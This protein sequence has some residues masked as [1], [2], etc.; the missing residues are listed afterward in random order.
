[1]PDIDPNEL[2]AAIN[3]L[4]APKTS[5]DRDAELRAAG[6]FVADYGA[7]GDWYEGAD[8]A[9]L[10]FWTGHHDAAWYMIGHWS[11][12]RNDPEARPP[13]SFD[14]HAAQCPTC[15][16]L[17]AAYGL[18]LSFETQVCEECGLDLDKHEIVPD[19]LGLAYASCGTVDWTR[20]EPIVHGNNWVGG[21]PQLEAGWDTSWWAPLSYD[22]ENLFA[23]VTRYYYLAQDTDGDG[24]PQGDP[25]VEE[26]TEYLVCT[27]WRHPG[28]TELN[29]DTQYVKLDDPA[30]MDTRQLA[31]D[32][33]EP[34]AGEWPAYAPEP[35]K[36][37]LAVGPAPALT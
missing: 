30:T 23:V 10:Q 3:Q 2:L 6:N 35:Y 18:Y 19:A 29:S 9:K 33:P 14:E 34:E 16:Y 13:A 26:Q 36:R 7:L 31:M 24:E 8:L 25:Y 20:R 5:Y 28:D 15:K 27:D 32:A 21:D 4:M 17:E 1:M 11:V 22:D 37:A 12:Q